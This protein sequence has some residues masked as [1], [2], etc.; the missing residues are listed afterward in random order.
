MLP[1]AP[2]IR[3]IWP[4][5]CTASSPVCQ[6]RQRGARAPDRRNP[7]VFLGLCAPLSRQLTDRRFRLQ[8]NCSMT[9]PLVDTARC[10]CQTVGV[11]SQRGRA[12]NVQTPPVERPPITDPYA[13]F[14]VP[15]PG[16]RNY[17]YPALLSRQLR[18]KPKRVTMLGEHLVIWRE[19]NNVYALADRCAHRG[20]R[21]SRGKCEFPGSGTIT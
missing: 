19:N 8:A 9:E 7:A 11:I 10:G 14:K 4:D 13:R 2:V 16:F 17:W 12:V 6:L 18:S 1:A 20:A 21:L 15:V 3:T 5:D